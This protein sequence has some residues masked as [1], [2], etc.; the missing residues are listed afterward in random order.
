MAQTVEQ[1]AERKARHA[2]YARQNFSKPDNYNGHAVTHEVDEN[3]ALSL[4]GRYV[5]HLPKIVKSLRGLR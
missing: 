5:L 3:Y 4:E 1:I 2:Q